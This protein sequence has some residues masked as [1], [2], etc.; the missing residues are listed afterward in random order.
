[1]SDIGKANVAGAGNFGCHAFHDG[2]GRIRVLLACQA[3]HWN[4]NLAEIGALVE[5]DQAPHRRAISVG[6]HGAHDLDGV[7]AA[8]RVRGGPHHAV[9]ERRRQVGHGLA[10]I[11]R[12]QAIGDEFLLE[13][14][15]GVSECRAGAG[16]HRGAIAFRAAA[17]H[18]L[19][20]HAAHRMPDQHGPLQ[21]ALGDRPARHPWQAHRNPLPCTGGRPP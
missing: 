12:C 5:A 13:I 19:R 11:E 20:H 4:R 10:G 17:Q 1:M 15:I 2:G 16:E 6:G 14:P 8:G 21:A 18:G 9:H 7:R 3:Q